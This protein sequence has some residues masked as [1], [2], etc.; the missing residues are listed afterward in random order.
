MACKV[1]RGGKDINK[2]KEVD[3]GKVFESNLIHQR[4]SE[5]IQEGLDNL[6]GYL[7]D[8]LKEDMS[9]SQK[10]NAILKMNA[11]I[12]PE[13]FRELTSS[14]PSVDKSMIA[15]KAISAIKDTGNFL[16]KKRETEMSEDINLNSPKFQLIF[17]WFM[18]LI[19]EI[20]M[21]QGLNTL[22]VNNIFNDL[23]LELTG[24]E[25][26]ILKRLKG[27]SSKALDEVKN[28]LIEKIRG[29]KQNGGFDL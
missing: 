12:I 17:T 22:Q 4:S 27:L 14:M 18:E 21:R 5:E 15:S 11:I 19:N 6:E 9:F 25:D 1:V 8:L 24:W 13:F 26:K 29:K 7:S 10:M 20:L 16:I 28:P 2:D 23:S 3:S